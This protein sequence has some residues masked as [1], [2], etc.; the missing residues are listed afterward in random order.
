MRSKLLLVLGFNLEVVLDVIVVV[1]VVVS[2]VNV[3]VG[4]GFDFVVEVDLLFV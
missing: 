3:A 4:V 1:D 2:V